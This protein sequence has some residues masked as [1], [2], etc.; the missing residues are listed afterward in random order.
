MQNSKTFQ[1]F[2]YFIMPFSHHAHPQQ[3]YNNSILLY[4]SIKPLLDHF[5]ILAGHD[6]VMHYHLHLH[7]LL[8]N[9]G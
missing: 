5:S 3:H 7:Y 6:I 2:K 9:I 4:N 1:V 8:V